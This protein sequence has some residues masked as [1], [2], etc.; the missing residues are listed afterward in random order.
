M[1]FKAHTAYDIF[2]S[3]YKGTL[4]LIF[5]I[6]ISI[7]VFYIYSSAYLFTIPIFHFVKSSV[8]GNSRYQE[9]YAKNFKSGTGIQI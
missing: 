6:G 7:A 1:K 5:K 8:G 4:I 3:K 9:R 2:I